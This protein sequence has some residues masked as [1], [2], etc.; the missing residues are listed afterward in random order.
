MNDADGTHAKTRDERALAAV[1][2]ASYATLAERR[3]ETIL[4]ALPPSEL[5]A[6]VTRLGVRVDLTK[7]IDRTAQV[8]RAIAGQ[9]DVRDPS[10]QSPASRELLHR[11]AEAG[12][13]LVVA[14]VPVGLESLLARGVVFARRVGD[15]VELLLPTALLLQ[16][17]S[18]EG[19]DPR[20]LRALLQ[21]ISFETSSAIA[22][23]YLGRP[24]TPPLALALEVAW[25]VLGDERRLRD[26]VE[27]L[28]PAERRLLDA[29][30]HVGGEVDT[31]ELLDLE[32]EPLRL[33]GVG[34]VS[35]SRR[36]GGFALERR[37]FLMPLHPNRHVIPSEVLAI[38][39][40]ERLRAHD[41]ERARARSLV[42]S[43]DHAPRRARFAPDP[44]W[45]ALAMAM[46][47]REPGVE[48]RAAVGTPRSLLLKLSQ[49]F[50][51]DLESVALVAALSR[52]VGLWDAPA[53]LPA[54]P[55]GSLEVSALGASL[56]AAWRRGGAWDEGRSE[57]ELLRLPSDMRDASPVGVVRELLLEA[58][59][60]LGEGRWV[61]YEALSSYLLADSRVPG[62]ERLYRRWAER[63][64]QEPVPVSE[65]VRRLVT[66][67]L[68]TLGVVDLGESE[69][70][71]AAGASEGSLALRL[72]PRGRALLLG[73]PEAGR[74]R[75]GE[76][77]STHTLRV[78][79]GARVAHVLGLSQLVEVGAADGGL[80]LAITPQVLA[81]ALSAGLEG[82]TIRARL[83]ALAE[84]PQGLTA[85]LEQATA[86]LG[87]VSFVPA[88]G[89]LWADDP[90]LRELL[91]TRK[92]TAELFV[93]P[94]PPGGLLLAPEVDLDRLVRRCR[95][96]GIEI[97]S[98]GAVLRARG[99][100]TMPAV[101]TAPPEPGPRR[102]TLRPRSRTPVPGPA[103][104]GGP[105]RRERS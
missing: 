50:G 96:V 38:V 76:F 73:I 11:V 84:L 60:A 49:R 89:F 92:G 3:L 18:W 4:R 22:S 55:P 29:I 53:V 45:L 62:V 88:A 91:R 7:R 16:V 27:R 10:S 46:A 71:R 67:S 101:S 98:E 70:G 12:G 25:E 82:D 19:E 42:E 100:S 90:E 95:G 39:G 24:A 81:R 20:G 13:A 66:E 15:L 97:V 26:E 75:A 17:K 23:H 56:F 63:A 61:P 30:A 79:R 72:T 33:R 48:L 102:S 34:G 5:D 44:A 2:P 35:A 69:H 32:R 31:A 105:P 65:L 78:G 68:P 52:A 41:A 59:L 9:P 64:T 86:V 14:Q 99:S 57:R 83:R 85:M 51:R 28:P 93:D 37:G 87:R 58:L 40:E 104:A 6:M 77:V 1:A 103:V 94:S 43:E 21:V 80:D 36:G 54:T 47:V 74:S 8:A